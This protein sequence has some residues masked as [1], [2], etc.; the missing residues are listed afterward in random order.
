MKC[1]I[2]G[3]PNVGKS[4]LF[5]CL[6]NAKA[7]AANYPFA[8]IEPNVGVIPV[9]DERIAKLEALVN[10]ER[11]QQAIVEIVDIAGLVRGASKGEGL[12]N[13]FLANIR[14]TQAIIHVLRCFEND[15]ITH[16]DGSID[17]IRDKETID[18]ELQIKDLESVEKKIE[19]TKKRTRTGDKEA[20]KNLTVLE[21]YKTH[22]ESG[23]SARSIDLSDK[24]KEVVADLMLL[25]DKP[26][27]YICCLLYTSPSPRDVEES[28]MPSS[29]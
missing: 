23:K 12:G 8:T 3:L 2:V 20:L 9:P 29:A 19:T 5:N 17:P 15:N 16:V 26:I 13:K 10:P 25:T 14:E 4:T 1:G 22:L 11:V 6:S 21:T 18:L 7:L 28:R 24:E 27:L